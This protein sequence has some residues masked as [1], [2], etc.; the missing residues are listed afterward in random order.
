[1]AVKVM[2]NH[3]TRD[4]KPKGEC[5]KCDQ[6]WERVAASAQDRLDNGIPRKN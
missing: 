5:P 6:Y 2:H 3:L 4:I 1:M